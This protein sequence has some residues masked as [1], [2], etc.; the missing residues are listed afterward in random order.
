MSGKKGTKRWLTPWAESEDRTSVYH[1]T[2]RVVDRRFVFGD[3]ERGKFRIARFPLQ[4]SR[5]IITNNFPEFDEFWD[6][7]KSKRA[8]YPYPDPVTKERLFKKDNNKIKARLKGLAG[9]GSRL[10][11]IP[12]L[13]FLI[14][15]ATSIAKGQDLM[16]AAQEAAVSGLGADLV[17]EGMHATASL[18]NDVAQKTIAPAAKNM[19]QHNATWKEIADL[20]DQM[21]K[22]NSDPCE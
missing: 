1:L 22:D 9:K 6:G 4:D 15:G 11:R 18:I 21:A 19:Q 10:L 14:G 13:G 20:H 8:G 17:D 12:G 7:D 5:K 16:T 3:E 2:S